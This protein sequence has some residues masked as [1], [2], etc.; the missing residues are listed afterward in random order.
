MPRAKQAA[1]PAP[2]ITVIEPHAVLFVDDAIR[3]LRLKLSTVRREV[4]QGRLRISKR[5]GR[6]YMLGEWI[7]EW[8][9]AGELPRRAPLLARATSNGN[10]AEK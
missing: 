4:R 9:R 1:T 8:L 3:I 5:A 6:Y 2:A 10:G 7:L